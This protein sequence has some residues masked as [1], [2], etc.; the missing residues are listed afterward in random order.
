MPTSLTANLPDTLLGWLTLTGVVV[1]ALWAVYTF[2][3][4][5]R[6]KHAELLLKLEE[7]YRNHLP[8]MLR[9]EY[10]REY[11]ASVLPALQRANST[12]D[13]SDRDE[14]GYTESESKAIDSLELVLRHFLM[15][16]H[17]RDL[18]VARSSIDR[19]HSYYLRLF[20][21][22][23]HK[24][25]RVYLRRYWPTVYFWAGLAGRPWAIR[26]VL[27]VAQVP[28][29]LR[30]WVLSKGSEPDRARRKGDPGPLAS[31]RASGSTAAVPPGIAPGQADAKPSSPT[32]SVAQ[33]MPRL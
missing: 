18:G 29:R 13:T 8:T 20:V 1:G 14:V 21:N 5:T 9:L 4:N 11:K 22:D 2:W 26:G 24:D 16:G 25:L 19:S 7:N 23:D 3:A 6:S 12:S 32:E 31:E 15:A 17:L 33:L 10:L 30:V 27:F 28:Q